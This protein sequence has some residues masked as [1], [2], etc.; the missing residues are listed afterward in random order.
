MAETIV[1]CLWGGGGGRK[2]LESLEDGKGFHKES[3]LEWWTPRG[4]GG[5]W[6]SLLLWRMGAVQLS[7][8][9]A[10][11]ADVWEVKRRER[12]KKGTRQGVYTYILA[13]DW[14]SAS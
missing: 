1:R 2:K 8:E 13:W 5:R 6:S 3:V 4:L 14:S 7:P 12:E 9:P 10:I 11:V